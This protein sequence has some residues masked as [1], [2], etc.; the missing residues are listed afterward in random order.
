MEGVVP[1]LD[2]Q[3]ND[4]FYQGNL[5]VDHIGHWIGKNAL[6]ADEGP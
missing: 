6:N 4:G 2:K 5:G 3:T 1:L